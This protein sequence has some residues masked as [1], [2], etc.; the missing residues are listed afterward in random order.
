LIGQVAD[1]GGN[2]NASIVLIRKPEQNK[3]TGK[4]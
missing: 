1:V 3:T 2:K 4:S